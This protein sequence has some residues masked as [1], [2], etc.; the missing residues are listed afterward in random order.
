[1]ESLLIGKYSDAGKDQGLEEKG[2]TENKMVGWHHQLDPHEFGSTPGFGDGQGGVAC[3][4][5]WG[6]KESGT[7]KRLN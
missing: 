7:T 5:S 1:M 4:G 6:R 2:M 3:C